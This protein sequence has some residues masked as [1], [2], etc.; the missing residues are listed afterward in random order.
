MTEYD[1]EVTSQSEIET[2]LAGLVRA[3]EGNSIVGYLSKDNL[4]NLQQL[5]DKAVAAAGTLGGRAKYHIN[6]LLEAGRSVQE[7]EF[8]KALVRQAPVAMLAMGDRNA[9]EQVTHTLSGEGFDPLLWWT[10]SPYVF[11]ELQPKIGETDAIRLLLEWS[12]GG[13]T[14]SDSPKRSVNLAG[15]DRYNQAKPN[16]SGF[17]LN[18]D[19]THF[20]H[21]F[22][23]Q[24]ARRVIRQ[25]TIF[26]PGR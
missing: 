3:Q 9:K 25:V 8:G 22:A 2:F 19:S 23:R 4:K 11:A 18:S 12:K 10:L 6:R 17:V 14:M 16:R 13:K 15:L 7:S 5:G 20:S 1:T 21:Q 24:E 26:A